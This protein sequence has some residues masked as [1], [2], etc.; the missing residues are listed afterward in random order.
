M[1]TMSAPAASA[2]VV[3]RLLVGAVAFVDRVA[4]RIEARARGD[5]QRR[6][7]ARVVHERTSSTTSCGMAPIAR[8]E[9]LLARYAGMTTMTRWP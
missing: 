7:V 4:D 2:A 8:C 6:V 5:P 1:T 9:R 3:A